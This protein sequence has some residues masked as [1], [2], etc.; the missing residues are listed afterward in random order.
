MTGH[1]TG[2]VPTPRSATEG[3]RVISPP[4]NDSRFGPLA[5]VS[6]EAALAESEA[7][8]RSAFE[9]GV[10]GMAFIGL[11]DRFLRVN[12]AWCETLGYA[13]SELLDKRLTDVVHPED[14]VGDGARRSRPPPSGSEVLTER[15][16]VRKDGGTVWVSAG[17]R[18]VLDADGVPAYFVGQFQNVT[19][20]HLAEEQR[21]R[22]FTLSLELLMIASMEGFFTRL[23]P[24]WER[25]LGFT[26]RELF[27]RPVMDLV[28]P[29]D[30]EA[31]RAEASRLAEG[32]WTIGFQNRLLGADG[33]YRWL[34]W[35]ASASPADRLVYAVGRDVSHRKAS[36]RM[37]RE[38]VSTVSHEL[39]TPLTAMRGALGL[40]ESGALGEM[41]ARAV[42]VTRIAHE[43]CDRLVRLV[44]DI[45]DLERI[46]AGK[47]TLRR[48]PVEPRSV[49]TSSVDGLRPLA[50]EA[51]VELE[52]DLGFEG[53]VSLDRDRTIQVVTNLL[54]NAIKFSP[55]GATVRVRVEAAGR[56]HVRF[57]VSD[58]GIGIRPEDVGSLFR[59]FH[60]LDT[61]ERRQS[62][63][64]GLGLSISKA[65][66]EQ[67]GGRIGV[68]S[69]PGRGST[70]W[71]EIPLA[72]RPAGGAG[73][74]QRR[75]TGAG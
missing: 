37:Q 59:P 12:R 72:G 24:A 47:L 14:R 27:A 26:N 61:E 62:G 42:E 39:R 20:R 58:E 1:L 74:T 41:P 8:F 73:A 7:R 10:A 45:L 36:E 64:T 13:E 29:D 53:V 33:G 65:I 68:A 16:F 5:A 2:G 31:T 15:R 9:C 34:E 19:A 3:A 57:E 71:F 6:A 25:L 44:N 23:N 63:G 51:G 22:F 69:A 50:I 11:D 35:S 66:V 4:T 28:H 32:Q 54:S 30:R 49:V 46:D 56:D 21:G 43:S 48:A 67:H 52:A 60:Q 70:F 40:L 38:F 55:A 18:C 75:S 17:I